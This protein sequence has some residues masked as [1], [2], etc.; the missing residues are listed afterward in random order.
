MLISSLLARIQK[1][2]YM[3]RE[4]VNEA[5]I[6]AA[7]AIILAPMANQSALQIADMKIITVMA[8]SAKIT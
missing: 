6:L 2:R 8:I 5:F 3:Y 7:K 1:I 4:S